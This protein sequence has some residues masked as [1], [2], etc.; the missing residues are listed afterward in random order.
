MF[1]CGFAAIIY[2]SETNSPPIFFLPAKLET[3]FRKS[4]KKGHQTLQGL[5]IKHCLPKIFKKPFVFQQ[6]H[7]EKSLWQSFLFLVQE[8]S[9]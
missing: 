2:S 7:W 9:V 8:V 6:K 5:S 1:K 4:Q 3:V